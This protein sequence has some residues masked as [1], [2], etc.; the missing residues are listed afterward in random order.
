MKDG[1]GGFTPDKAKAVAYLKR[2]ARWSQD[3][4]KALE[5]IGEQP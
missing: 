2:A 3:A 5:E 1:L 4:K